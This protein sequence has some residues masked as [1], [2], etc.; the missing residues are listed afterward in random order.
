[1]NVT[2]HDVAK[3]AGVSIKTVSR[4]INN[5][6]SVKPDTRDKVTRAVEEL[7]YQPN[8]S[9]RNLA[10]TASYEVGF[11]YD[12]PNAYYVIEM[13][14]GMLAECR[15]QGYELI[16][17]PC[18][19]NA[20]NIIE[21]IVATAK[22]SRLA[23]LLLTPPFSENPQVIFALKSNNIPFVRIVSG[24]EAPDILSPC[25]YIDDKHAAFDITCHL[26][27]TGYKK[28]GFIAGEESHKSTLERLNGYK[29][30]LAEHGVAVNKKLIYQGRY[31]FEEGV[32]GAKEL[33]G[34]EI[35]PDAI[36]AC[37][38]EIAAGALFAARLMGIDVPGQLAIAGFEGSP[39][40]RQTWPK[41]TTA[42]QP[43]CEIARFAAS[44]LLSHIK[45]R[46]NEAVP[47]KRFV[48]RLVVRDSTHPTKG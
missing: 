17:H 23:G 14:N 41:L 42:E 21:E 15:K 47:S 37:N 34:Q 22:K 18:D 1:M 9:A 46:Q 10:S 12:N 7:N 38:D 11:I 48:P 13:Q 24:S 30:A 39:F 33:L 2:I 4:V 5:E 32:N 28:I 40:S 27:E 3:R 44:L 20:E 8:Q 19:S 6:P 36:F 35:K 29:D 43:T 31:S 16:I 25:V 26:L 45:S